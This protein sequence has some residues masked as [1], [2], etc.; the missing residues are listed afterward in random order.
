MP[1]NGYT[2]SSYLMAIVMIGITI[3]DACY[4]RYVS[5]VDSVEE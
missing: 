1:Q 2:L 5:N 4:L 3:L